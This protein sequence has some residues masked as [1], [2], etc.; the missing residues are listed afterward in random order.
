MSNIDFENGTFEYIE[1]KLRNNATGTEFGKHFE[2]VLTKRP[3]IQAI[4]LAGV[5]VGRLARAMGTRR[6]NGERCGRSEC[7]S[8]SAPRVASNS[9]EHSI[10]WGLVTVENKCDPGASFD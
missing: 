2:M 8:Y 3:Q 5:V 10:S 4:D 1:A 6:P 9:S 7:L